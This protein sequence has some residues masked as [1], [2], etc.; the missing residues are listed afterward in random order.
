M[1]DGIGGDGVVQRTRLVNE[2]VT[3]SDAMPA[4]LIAM[5]ETAAS[6]VMVT[7]APTFQVAPSSE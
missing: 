1:L 7:V 4:G 2:R 6:S 5:N 3:T